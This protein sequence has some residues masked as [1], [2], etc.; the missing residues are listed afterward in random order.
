MFTIR[1][2]SKSVLSSLKCNCSIAAIHELV[3]YWSELTCCHVI[4]KLCVSQF[5]D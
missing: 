3:A 1:L 2:F 4:I 5:L